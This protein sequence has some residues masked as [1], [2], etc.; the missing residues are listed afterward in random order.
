MLALA[1]ATLFVVTGASHAATVTSNLI[2]GLVN[3]T[4][5]DGAVVPMAGFGL[6]GGSVSV[7]GPVLEANE[8]D[9]LVINLTNSLPV[10]IT[11]VVHGQRI[12]N[13]T[14]VDVGGRVLSFVPHSGSFTFPNLKAGTYLY[15]SGTH[16]AVEVPM[17]LY[18]VLIVRPAT[19]G[20]A[21]N[22]PVSA[23]DTEHVVVFSDVDP[24]LNTMVRTGRYG[25]A[26]YPSTVKY[27]PKY[28]LVNGKAYP[29]TV[30]MTANN[31]DRV[32][33][34]LV[35]AGNRD[36]APTLNGLYSMVIAED[37]NLL[38]FPENDLAVM[39][40]AGKTKDVIVTPGADTRYTLYDRRLN[41]SNAGTAGVGGILTFLEVGTVPPLSPLKKARTRR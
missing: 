26:L 25:S 28:F 32:L 4:M 17:G 37:G 6:S 27:A 39:L 19:P 22:D 11:V 33:L 23:Y 14:P 10:P 18:G 29:Q 7:P 2:T 34:R 1:V 16:P 5:P 40:P 31:G 21:Y 13:P 9:T 36:Y 30:P 35:N 3:V 38:P 15:E 41:L 8:G 20:Q 12:Q 24:V